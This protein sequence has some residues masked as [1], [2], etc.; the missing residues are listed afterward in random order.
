[1]AIY[2]SSSLASRQLQRRS[3]L[4]GVRIS[5]LLHGYSSQHYSTAVNG[6][7]LH[8]NL[9]TKMYF[10]RNHPLSYMAAS[11]QILHSLAHSGWVDGLLQGSANLAFALCIPIVAI[12]AGFAAAI[13][14]FFSA[15]QVRFRDVGWLCPFCSR[16][17]CSPFRLCTP[18]NPYRSGSGAVLLDP[19]AGLIEGFRLV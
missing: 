9:L 15:L 4:P 7:V 5:A 18:C 6:L 8:P 17:G 10:R 16:C 2:R 11:W 3:S 13:A 1:M 14:L 19:V 12:L